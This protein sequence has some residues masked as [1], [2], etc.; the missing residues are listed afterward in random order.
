MIGIGPDH[1][2]L[3]FKEAIGGWPMLRYIGGG[4]LYRDP[5]QAVPAHE[6]AAAVSAD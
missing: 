2:A 1:A 6:A 5:E 4:L 3:E